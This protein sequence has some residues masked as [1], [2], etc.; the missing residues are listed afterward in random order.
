MSGEDKNYMRTKPNRASARFV[1]RQFAVIEKM[2]S[3]SK[4]DALGPGTDIKWRNESV[5]KKNRR[6]Y[7]A[8]KSREETPK[9]GG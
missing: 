6:S 4:I 9:K 7:P 2:S 1:G 3:T 8:A 5:C